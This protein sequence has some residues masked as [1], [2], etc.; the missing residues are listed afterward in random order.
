MERDGIKSKSMRSEY[1]E[2]SSYVEYTSKGL[3]AVIGI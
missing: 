3:T 1:N 2:D